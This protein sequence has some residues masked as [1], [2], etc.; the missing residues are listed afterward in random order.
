MFRDKIGARSAPVRNWV[1]RGAVRKFADSI[2]DPN[3]LYRDEAAAARSRWGR[4]IA[5]PTF[6]RVFEYGEIDGIR[7]PPVG[8]IHGE[9]EYQYERPLFVGEEVVCT[10]VL[11]NAYEKQGRSGP[12]TFLVFERI[13]ETPAGERI[14][15]ATETYVLTETVMRSMAG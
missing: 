4:P 5:P 1:E 14:F 7:L 10:T 2:G 15:V 8:V 3:P 13:G 9:Q 11:G 12:M 6:P